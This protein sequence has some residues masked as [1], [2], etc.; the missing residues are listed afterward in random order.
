MNSIHTS[1][2]IEACS[3]GVLVAKM[4]VALYKPP[5]RGL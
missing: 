4:T 2:L 5:T 1:S 3:A